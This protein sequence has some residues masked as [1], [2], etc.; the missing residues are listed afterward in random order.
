MASKL[1]R[2][3]PE[4]RA[5]QALGAHDPATSGV[6][7][8]VQFSTT[9]LRA[10]DN[11]YPSGRVYGRGDNPTGESAEAVLASLESGQEAL[12]FSSGMSAAVAVFFSLKP[13]DHVVAPQ[14]MYWALRLWLQT[15]ATEWGLQ[16][17]FVA[18]DNLAAVRQAAQPGRTKLIWIETPSNPTWD[19]TDIA[20]IAEIARTAG[21]RLVV[22]NTVP[23]PVHTRPLEL[24]AHMVMHSATKYLNGHSDVIAGALVT[25][26]RDDFW[27]RVKGFRKSGGAI[28]GPLDAFLL[29][30][31]MRTLFLR[32][33]K[34]SMTAQFLAERLQGHATLE[35]VLYPGLPTHPAHGI[36]QK[37]MQNGYGGMLSIIVA[38]GAPKAIEVAAK[39]KLWVRATSLG[40]PESLIE[41]RASVEGS[42]SPVP[43]G[44]LR[45]SVGLEQADDLL[46]DL[47][48]ALK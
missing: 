39:V 2:Y 22:D 20:A 40:G 27:V 6:L 46:D 30:R 15:T 14:V 21:A 10:R 41:H 33:G 29:L 35:N 44:L 7:P 37:Q 19:I 43:P 45:L 42:N 18:M 26:E 48:L 34:S 32:V 24:G 5:A 17:T 8:P 47:K 28:L 31:G 11:S 1:S 25:A 4:T 3:H 38:G 12:I 9:Y 16:V 13:G 36:A 23:T